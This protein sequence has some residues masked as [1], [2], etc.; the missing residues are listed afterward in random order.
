MFFI[1]D[2]G[3]TIEVTITWAPRE[4]DVG[5]MAEYVWDYSTPDNEPAL[6]ETEQAR[7]FKEAGRI[8][9]PTEYFDY[10]D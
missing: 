9:P 10:G 7:L 8:G 4:P 5:I 2:N 1:R 6:S 3:R